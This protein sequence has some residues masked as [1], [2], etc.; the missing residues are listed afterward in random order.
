MKGAAFRDWRD[1]YS[2]LASAWRSSGY[3]PLMLQSVS[4]APLSLPP[5]FV[6][7]HCSS[8]KLLIASVRTASPDLWMSF[9]LMS[10]QMWTWVPGR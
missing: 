8:R 9:N 10:W 5:L 4:P 7:P 6:S 2:L 1:S 3:S